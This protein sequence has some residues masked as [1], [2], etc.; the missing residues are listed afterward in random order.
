[1]VKNTTG[2]SRRV[3]PPSAT[4][5]ALAGLAHEIRTPLNGVLALSELLATAD[6]PE[7][8]R[9]WAAA[10]KSA[11][12]HLAALT[13]I[14][15]DGARA[16]RK[17]L[18]LREEPFAPAALIDELRAALEARAAVKG[19]ASEVTI[20]SA[21]PD[22]V[23]GDKVRL[24][25]ALENLIDNA[26]KFTDTG[27]VSLTVDAG[28]PVRGR[29]KLQFSVRDC[30]PGLTATETRRLFKPFAQASEAV[31]RRYGGAGLGLVFV[32]RVAK[33]M[34]GDLTVESAPGAGSTFHMSVAVGCPAPP[35]PA[36]TPAAPRTAVRARA[37]RILCVEDNPYGRMVLNSIVTA[38]GHRPDFVG[39][40][41]AALTAA[42]AQSYDL[43]LMDL[44]LPDM[45]GIEAIR[46]LK[47]GPGATVPVL[48]VSGRSED[49]VAREAEAAGA[50]AF[51]PKPLTP[52][53]LA[54]ALA[55][56]PAH[57]RKRAKA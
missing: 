9:Q 38:W 3:A 6:L 27:T 22:T 1:M 29:C 37:L 52:A 4:E 47:A 51:L 25:A 11:A 10:I 40:G 7:R 8:E 39:T 12:E 41:A 23:V 17:R 42:A 30:G 35:V 28:K 26:V 49:A 20:G 33:A 54:A 56:L 57:L 24:R 32:K 16:G 15:V 44:T 2:R 55:G 53:A 31:G 13:T 21:L 34:G 18:V 45:S 48:A 43:V 36:A 14:V 5:T 46:Q 50:A 19:L